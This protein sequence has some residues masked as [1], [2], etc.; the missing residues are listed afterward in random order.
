MY[1]VNSALASNSDFNMTFTFDG[2][3]EQANDYK[4]EP[5]TKPQHSNQD[6]PCC[7][8]CLQK[9]TSYHHTTDS[10]LY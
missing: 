4:A 2:T 5:L 8:Y 1:D 6:S 7:S 9:C 10:H 3:K